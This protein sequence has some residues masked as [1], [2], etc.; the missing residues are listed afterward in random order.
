MRALPVVFAALLL[1][2]PLAAGP[3]L[4]GV[5]ATG[6]TEETVVAESTGTSSD[7]VTAESGPV[8]EPSAVDPA[9]GTTAFGPTATPAVHESNLTLRTLSTP[10]GAE[11]RV[12]AD[13]RTANLGTALG[14]AAGEADAALRTEATVQRIESAASN[15]ERQQRILAAISQVE[16]DEVSLNSRQRSAIEAHAAGELSDRELLDELVR[17][18]AVADEYDRRLEVLGELAADTDGFSA[19][20]RV[21]EL[22]VRLEV[23]NGPVRERALETVRASTPSDEVYVESSPT[24]VVLATID[25]DQYVRESFRYDRWNRGGGVITS[26]AGINATVASYPETTA[27]REPNA[28]GAGAV[29]R[30]T[31]PHDFGLLRTFV[32]GGTERVFAEHQRVDLARFP[33]YEPIAADDDG[34]NVTVNRTYRGGPVTV[35]V[36]GEDGEPVTGVT[37]TKSVG[38]DESEAIGTT[39]ADGVVRTVSPAESYRIT[40]IDEP[41]VAVIDG[42]EPIETPRLVDDDGS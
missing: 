40:V 8:T 28:F 12:G 32:S 21:D 24:G 15:A 6:P 4:A 25:G 29:Q 5:T 31:V 11:P 13:R 23:Y 2:A 34:F 18:S 38:D 14:L 35:T 9:V 3:S 37:V 39:N 19:P 36:R 7:A 27:L 10:V 17:V 42:V 41:R 30:I 16:Q 33:D 22:Q 26:E 1:L 20:G